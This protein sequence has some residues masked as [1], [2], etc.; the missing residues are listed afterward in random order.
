MSKSLKN[1][2][3]PLFILLAILLSPARVAAEVF[4]ESG[5]I[6]ELSNEVI[7][8]GDTFLR[9]SPTVKIKTPLKNKAG[10][11]DLKVGDRVGVV[12]V[13]YHGKRYAGRIVVLSG[14]LSDE[15]Q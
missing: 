7:N 5:E 10:L 1:A 15:E 9:I 6:Y 14:E 11:Q 12:V 8:V 13:I 4:D 2:F 3:V